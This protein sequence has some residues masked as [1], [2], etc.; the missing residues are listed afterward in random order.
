VKFLYWLAINKSWTLML[1]KLSIGSMFVLDAGCLPW[2]QYHSIQFDV[3]VFCLICQWIDTF[4]DTFRCRYLVWSNIGLKILKV[5]MCSKLLQKNLQQYDVTE[6]KMVYRSL[7][8]VVTQRP[9]YKT[10]YANRHIFI[11]NTQ[12]DFIF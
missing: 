10:L 12:K 7:W 8:N 9:D 2:K 6:C 5:F 11:I 1:K 4:K 3:T